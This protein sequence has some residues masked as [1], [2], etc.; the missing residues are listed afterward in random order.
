MSVITECC[1]CFEEIDS[2]KNNCVT[3]CGHQ[4]C[5][6]CIA[7]CLG[8]GHC[9]P[10]CRGELIEKNENESEDGDEEDDSDYE[11][12]DDEDEEENVEYDEDENIDVI[13][14][15]FIK[16]GYDAMDLVTMILGRVKKS[17]PKYTNQYIKKMLDDFDETVEEIEN[18]KREQEDFAAE[19]KPIA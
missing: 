9:C 18:Q 13:T 1:V 10:I 3:P 14:E 5:F 2:L 4:F 8:R 17:N 11:D 19:D 15:N 16:K 6:V 12:S 7:K